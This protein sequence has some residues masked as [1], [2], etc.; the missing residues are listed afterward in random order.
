MNQ[1]IHTKIHTHTYIYTILGVFFK[2]DKSS[3]FDKSCTNL[4]NYDDTANFQNM[5]IVLISLREKRERERER[6]EAGRR[7]KKRKEKGNKSR[8]ERTFIRSKGQN[9]PSK[10]GAW[11]KK[12]KRKKEGRELDRKNIE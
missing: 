11:K 6:K 7:G 12:K 8:P 10:R 9:H 4:A 5:H 2:R 3:P 1:H